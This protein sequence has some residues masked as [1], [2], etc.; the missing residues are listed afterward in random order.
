MKRPWLKRIAISVAV[1]ACAGAVWW[2]MRNPPVMVD[3]AA[4]AEAPMRV[5]IR[6]EG[7]TRVRDIYTVSAPIGGHLSRSVLAEGDKVE[8]GKTVLASIHPLDPPLLDRRTEAEL[9][10]ARDA[11][12]SAVGIAQG[13]LRQAEMALS[14][15]RDSLGRALKLFGPGVISETALEKATNEVELQE[16]AVEAA[17]AAVGYRQ[18]ELA[19]AE[20]RL[21]QTSDTD[22]VGAGC[23]IDVLAPSS[24]TVLAVKARSE[25]AIAAGAVIAE[26]GDVSQLEIVVD[27]LSSDAIRVVPGTPTDITEWGGDKVLQAR[28]RKIDPAAFTKVSAL[29]I[30][31]QRVSAVLDLVDSD[32]RLGHAFRVVAELVVWS[33]ES[34]L[35]VPISALYRSGDEWQAFAV[36]DG[37]AQEKPVTVGRFNDISA[38]VLGGLSAGDRVVTHPNDRM[39]DGVRVT[40]RR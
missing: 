1:F 3:T 19:T 37:R 35:Q 21:L 10:A 14:L 17:R 24:G 30:E 36:V 25:Q 15:S 39:F 8:A 40:E 7:R 26:I 11:A 23:C 28:V 9:H 4:V 13:E 12:R 22:T 20:A 6:E 33:C 31:E 16:A 32:A 27:L 29:G 34:C 18:A 2:G 38:Q 5:T